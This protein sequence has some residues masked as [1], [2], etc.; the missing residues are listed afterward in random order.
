MWVVAGVAMMMSSC[1][2]TAPQLPTNVGTSSVAPEPVADDVAELPTGLPFAATEFALPQHAVMPAT[3]AT[4]GPHFAVATAH[5]LASRAA[6]QVLR[7]GGTAVDAFIAASLVLTVVAPQSTG[8]G[9]G[10]FAIVWPGDQRPARAIDFRETAPAATDLTD[11]RTP[12]GRAIAERT[13]HHGL[14]V[15]TPGYV[16]G[17]WRLHRRWGAL[18][19]NQLV[20][21][22]IDVAARGFAVGR[23]LARA[24]ALAQPFMNAP[25]RRVFLRDGKPLTRGDVLQQPALART[26]QRLAD[27]GPSAFYAGETAADMV[28]TVQAAGGK[29]SR[30]DLMTYEVREF[31]PLTGRVADLDVL[32]MPQPSAGGAQLLAMA[33]LFR[34]ESTKAPTPTALAHTMAEAMRRSFLLRLAYVGD[35]AKPAR[36]LDD[37]FPQA[38]RHALQATFDPKRATPTGKLPALPIGE[39]HENTSHVSVVDGNGMAVA[40]THTVNLYLGSALVTDGGILLNNEM[41]DFTIALQDSNAF[42]LAGSAANLARPG[43]RPV[44]SMSPAIFL[45]DN[46]PVLV[47]GSPGGTRIP[48]TVFQVVA[49]HLFLSQSLADAV[50]A[51]RVHHQALPDVVQVEA[52]PAGDAIAAGLQTLGH[53]VERKPPWCNVQ[54]VRRACDKSGRCVLEAASDPRVEGGVIAE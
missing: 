14:A 1:A 51:V 49:R 53:T 5:P 33:E 45:R 4:P 9:G 54:A 17:L 25:A 46:Q 41:D 52:T 40:S 24:V 29:L 44:S 21:P 11:Y 15:A 47:V 10:G 37:A 12:E 18:P 7:A 42:G 23:E 50:A 16:A 48:T 34:A 19:W 30:D 39:H 8:I 28:R 3:D 26:L 31:A 27:I 35:V 32:T 20:Q 6:A 38:A 22:A 13:Q 2:A 36:T 43:A